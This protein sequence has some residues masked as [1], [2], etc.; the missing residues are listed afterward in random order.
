MPDYDDPLEPLD[1]DDPNREPGRSGIVPEFVRKVAVAGLGALF[2]TEE[3]IR[4]LAG[5]LKLPKE[6][7]GH[8]LSQAEKTKDDIGRVI[9]EE[10]RRFLQS[11]KLREEFVKLM[12]GMTLEL[13]A[14]VRLKP[15]KSETGTAET[16]DESAPSDAGEP[17]LSVTEIRARRARKSKRE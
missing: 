1:P 3:G 5:Q 2:M 4:N 11:E 8:I 9:S 7:L 12:A 6:M 14:E 15:S 13:K 16:A 10:V 17:T